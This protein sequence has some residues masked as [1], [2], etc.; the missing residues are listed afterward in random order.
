MDKPIIAARKPCLVG[1]EAGKTYFWCRCGRS[2][3]QPF[4][5]GAHKGTDFTPLKWTAKEGGDQLFCACKHTRSEPFCD[6]SHNNLSAKYAEA[7][8]G[9]GEN[10]VL[11]DYAETEDGVQKAM[12]DNGCYVVRVPES[13]MERHGSLRVFPVIGARDGAMHLSQYLALVEPGNTPVQLFPGVD[14]TPFFRP[15]ARNRCLREA[16]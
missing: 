10:A 12:L 11:V 3:N 8:A 15:G 16:R 5:D 9:D 13:A 14:V 2:Q 4:C 6:G 1:V 7:E